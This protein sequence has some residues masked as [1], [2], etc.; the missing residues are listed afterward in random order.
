MPIGF[1]QNSHVPALPTAV[2]TRGVG[3]EPEPPLHPA[4][5]VNKRIEKHESKRAS[6]LETYRLREMR[7]I[8]LIFSCA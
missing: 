2:V 4:A 7:R 3:Y 8:S 1:R 5:A 6:R